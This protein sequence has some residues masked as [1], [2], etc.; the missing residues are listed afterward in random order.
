MHLTKNPSLDN[1][2]V[3]YYQF[4]ESSGLAYDKAGF[5]HASLSATSLR[6]VSTGPFGGGTSNTFNITSNNSFTSNTTNA[7]L[8]LAT[9]GTN[10]NGDVVVSRLNLSP[11][12]K[13]STHNISRAY[14]VIDNF[15]T[16]TIFTNLSSIIF[17]K[18]GVITTVDASNPSNFQLYTRNWNADGNTWG[19]L[20]D[21]AE[22]VVAGNDGSVT[23]STNNN[24]SNFGQFVIES[25]N[26]N[27]FLSSP[28]NLLQQ[29]DAIKVYPTLCKQGDAIHV[30][31]KNNEAGKITIYNEQGAKLFEQDIDNTIS[32]S[33]SN[34][35]A[36]SFFYKIVTNYHIQYGKI[37]L[38]Q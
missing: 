11:D 17:D 9:T 14:W 18:T 4:N 8:N 31:T 24:V 3:A 30:F 35:T 6:T 22:N 27:S 29:E 5:H 21:V 7:T 2:I 33:S 19:S 38:V 28:N 20:K 13:P 37:I 34:L 32:L 23:F 10:A 36:G 1:S 26:D 15:G 25:I 12:T 16:N